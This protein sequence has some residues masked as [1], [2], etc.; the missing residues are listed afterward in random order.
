MIPGWSAGYK[1]MFIDLILRD[2]VTSDARNIIDAAIERTGDNMMEYRIQLKM[3]EKNYSEGI[4]LAEKS[5]PGDF[6]LPGGKY[7]YL[8]RLNA[9]I[10]NS[11][12]TLKY[13]ESARLDLE[14]ALKNKPYN[15]SLHGLLG[16]VY[17]GCGNKKKALEEVENA[18]TMAHKKN[19][20][21]E[22]DMKLYRAQIYTLSGDYEN[23]SASIRFLLNNPSF[24][25]I[26]LLELDP[27]WKPLMDK[28]EY[29]KKIK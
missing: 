20:M 28:P 22:S 15:Y 7:I 11:D 5:S 10:N 3:Y 27:I 2:G 4:K 18:I 25:S 23:A 9:A 17:A 1:N 14:E 26:R 21:D 29:R 24:F 6:D 19:Q 13:Y 8:A 12:N 16:L